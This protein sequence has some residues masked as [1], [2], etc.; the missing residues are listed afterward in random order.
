MTCSWTAARLT[1]AAVAVAKQ[2][3]CDIQQQSSEGPTPVVLYCCFISDK[4][5]AS[6]CKAPSVCN[7]LQPVLLAETREGALESFSHRS[8]HATEH[9]NGRGK[10]PNLFG[11]RRQRLMNVGFRF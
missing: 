11:V 3:T 10:P 4:L 8:F 7:L 2:H 6:S 9:V 5:M 1:C